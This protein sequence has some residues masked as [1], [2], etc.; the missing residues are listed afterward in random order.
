M[1]S[2]A[3]VFDFLIFKNTKKQT[4]KQPTKTY[5]AVQG[6]KVQD[7]ALQSKRK[8]LPVFIFVS[9]S[10]SLSSHLSHITQRTN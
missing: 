2:E 8:H 3:S 9:S 4:K 6:K 5:N 1:I 7:N 10:P